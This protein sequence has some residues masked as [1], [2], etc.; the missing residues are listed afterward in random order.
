MGFTASLSDTSLFTKKDDNDIV[1][2]LLYVNDIILTCSNTSKINA[3]IQE[4]SEVFDLKDLG[5]LTFFLGLQI[6]YRDNEDIFVNQTKYIKD[7][8]HKAGLKSCKPTTTPYKPH[9]S[10]LVTEGKPLVDPSIYRSIVGSLQ[11]LTFTRPDIAFAVNSVCQ[12]MTSP[13]DDHLTAVKRILRYLQGTIEAGICYSAIAAVSLNAF[14]DAD[15][16]TT[17]SVTGYVV[18]VGNNL[19]SWQSK[20][21][22]SV[23][24][25]SIE[26][27]YKALAHTAV[28]IT[29]VRY[30][31]K[32]LNV[33]L[34]HPPVIS[35]DNM[36]GISLSA[37]LVF[38]SRIKHLDT[39]YHFVREKVQ[40]SDLEVVYIPTNDQTANILTKGLHSPT[41]VKHCYNL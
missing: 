40:Q 35:C 19:I 22:N 27:E 30:N 8:I 21:P 15:L 25:S 4:L 29:W 16:N 28:D 18:F 33:F 5:R 37:N 1:I 14:S 9:N 39:Y 36:S 11:Y 20:K 12:F 38:H 24:R 3:A 32:D 7:L 10:M 34:P 6:H 31:L 17:R 2:L 41:F 23:S 26:A 13:T